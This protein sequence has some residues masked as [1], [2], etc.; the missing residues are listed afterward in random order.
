MARL[1]PT[2]AEQRYELLKD[3]Q[4]LIVPGFLSESVVV[5]GVRLN[6]RSPYPSDYFILNQAD[7]DG[8]DREWAALMVS[9]LVWMVDG[10]PVFTGSSG[11]VFTIR[12]VVSTLPEGA[13]KKLFS[14]VLTLIKRAAK[15]RDNLLYYLYEDVSRDL[16]RGLGKQAPNLDRVTGLVGLEVLGLNAAQK[17]WVAWNNAEDQRDVDEYSWMM[18]KQ[19]I[20]P[21]APKAIEKMNK[22]ERQKEESRER[23]RAKSLDEW[24]Y[25]IRGVLDEDGKII[26]K[27]GDAIDPY[28]GDQ[29]SMAYTSDELAD[30][31]RR[32]VSGEMDWHDSVVKG[33]KDQIRENMLAERMQREE[34]LAEAA[35]E[36]QKREENLGIRTRNRLVGYTPQQLS[37]MM[38]NSGRD[39]SNPGARTVSYSPSRKQASFD[40]W[41]D[42]EIDSGALVV[43]DGKLVPKKEIPKPQKDNR[44]LQSKINSRLPRYDGGTD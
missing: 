19:S 2:T 16:W 17:I 20:A 29:V 26:T 39:L 40:K 18:T 23:D 9:R 24:Y 25:K 15:A 7:L 10:I 33:Y 27:D 21:H 32:W 30:E 4:S 12:S 3:T 44:S 38:Q 28:A 42:G 43:E 14:V 34:R 1:P 13:F 6:L 8:N 35:Q 37:E 41:V 11:S 36:I 22:Q 31:M 5:A